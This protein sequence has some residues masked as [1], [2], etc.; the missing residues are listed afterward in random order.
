MTVGEAPGK[1][2]PEP[3]SQLTAS[4]PPSSVRHLVGVWNPSYES[5]AMDAHIAVLLKHARTFAAREAAEDDVYVWWGKVRSQYRQAPLPHL[6]D[7]L[8]LDRQLAGEDESVEAHIYL[9]DY[10]SLYVAHLGAITQDDVRNDPAEVAHIPHYYIDGKLLTDCWFQLWDIRRLV[11]DDTTA[12]TQELRNLH[13][14]RYNDQ[15]VSLYGGMVD[16]P[17]IVRRP[18]EV[19]WFDTT[20]RAQLTEGRF[21]VEFD[22]E[23]AG[24]GEVQRELRD[25]RFGTR[26]WGNLDPAARGFVATAEQLFRAHRNDAAFDLSM[27]VVD[28]AKTFEVQVNRVLRASLAQAPSSVR[29]VNIDGHSRDLVREGPWGLGELGIAIA[30]DKGRNDWFKK[31]LQ[32]GEWFAVSLPPVMDAVRRLRNEGAHGGV[33][34]RERVVELRNELIGVGCK[35]SLVELAGVTPR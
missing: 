14:T 24:T 35:G 32:N 9:T 11:L 23:R 2:I 22:A 10:R 28:L 4:P 25:N 18:D 26:L 34:T 20:T 17:L 19:R 21:W 30:E 3:M 27:V 13:N 29:Y 8:A 7:V 31:H 33:V 6:G 15:R 1:S 12:V 5:D 16:L